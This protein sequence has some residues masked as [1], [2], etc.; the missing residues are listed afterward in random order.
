MRIH[1]TGNAAAGK[2]TLARELAAALDL[3]FYS[4]DS[5][6]WLPGWKQPPKDERIAAIQALAHEPTWVS[7]GVATSLRERADVVIVLD[8]PATVCALRALRRC[9]R[10]GR[11]SRPGFPSGCPEWKIAPALM[12]IIFGFP[13]RAG[14]AIC[15]DAAQAPER[16]RVL[17]WPTRPNEGAAE[18]TQWIREKMR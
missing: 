4:V 15:A 16:Y 2:T 12:R 17:S 10:Y 14:A 7:D 6:I 8:V 18:L 1:V 3:P 9:L 11:A 5:V 13:Q